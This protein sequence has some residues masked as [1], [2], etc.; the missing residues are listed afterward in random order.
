MKIINER[1]DEFS[2]D[3]MEDVNDKKDKILADI[4][5]EIQEEYD[6]EETAYYAKAYDDIQDGLKNIDREKNEI[7]S[8]AIIKNKTNLLNKRVDIINKVFES[9]RDE[10]RAFTKQEEYQEHLFK[11]IEED[12]EIIGKEEI[13]IIINA[14]DEALTT[15]LEKRFKAKIKV[16]KS[17]IDFIGGCKIFNKQTNA[18][19]DDSFESGLM[20]QKESFLQK[21]HLEIE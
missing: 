18:F 13:E 6:R 19:L 20:D 7:I 5:Q 17:N 8:Q 4:E 11:M 14:S 2:K 10:L 12:L 21:C 3:I 15:Q 1:L 9:A 16:E